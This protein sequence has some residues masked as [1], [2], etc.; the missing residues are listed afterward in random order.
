VNP[1]TVEARSHGAGTLAE[2]PSGKAPE[3]FDA[4][5]AHQVIARV[6][7]EGGKWTDVVAPITGQIIKIHHPLGDTVKAKQALFTI[8]GERGRYITTYLRA[9]QRA[10][11]ESGMAVDVRQ[12]A[13]SAKSFR[14]VVERIGPQYE[15]IPPAQLRDRK[16]EEWGLPVIL[17]VPI[18][19]DL[20]PGELV[21]VGWH[22]GATAPS[23]GAPKPTN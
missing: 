3:L 11:P 21:Y 13:D 7:A 12:R 10:R 4:V 1:E 19:V 8:A 6:E 5:T 2:P 23:N 15:P 16:A 22:D 9:E 14:A 17:A 18:D 20:R